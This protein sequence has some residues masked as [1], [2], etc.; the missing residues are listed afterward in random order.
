MNSH[1]AVTRTGP[2]PARDIRPRLMEEEGH[3]TGVAGRGREKC[4]GDKDGSQKRKRR[5][6]KGPEETVQE[7]VLAGKESWR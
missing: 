2:G 3:Q 7:V 5:E 1:S 4:R 6:R